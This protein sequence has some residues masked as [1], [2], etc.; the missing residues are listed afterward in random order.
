MKRNFRYS[1]TIIFALVLCIISSQNVFGWKLKWDRSTREADLKAINNLLDMYGESR[2]NEDIDEFSETLSDDYRYE[3]FLS[4]EERV[5][6]MRK[7]FDELRYIHFKLD[8]RNIELKAEEA[9]VSCRPTSIWINNLQGLSDDDIRRS[10]NVYQV[11]EEFR[12]AKEEAGFWRIRGRNISPYS[13]QIWLPEVAQP[14]S[15]VWIWLDVYEDDELSTGSAKVFVPETGEY[16]TCNDENG[17]GYFEGYFTAPKEPGNHEVI[18]HL[19]S[20]TGRNW[21]VRCPYRVAS[22]HPSQWQHLMIGT[23]DLASLKGGINTVAID[24]KGRLYFWDLVGGRCYR[25][26]GMNWERIFKY[27]T[28]PEWK[29]SGWSNKIIIDKDNNKWFPMFASKE[30]DEEQWG[31]SWVLKLND[32][33]PT[34][35]CECFTDKNAADFA[36]PLSGAVDMEGTVWIGDQDGALS[37]DGKDW[38]RYTQDDGLIHNIVNAITID[39]KGNR[40]FGTLYGISKFDG[41]KWENHIYDPWKRIS[42]KD[43]ENLEAYFMEIASAM[44][45]GKSANEILG[46][47]WGKYN[48]IKENYILSAASDNKGNVWF[49]TIGAGVWRY[50]SKKDEWRL[51]K[52]RDGLINNYI[53]SV[54]CDDEGNAW[55]CTRKGLSKFDGRSWETF[56]ISDGLC[57]RMLY[58]TE[59]GEQKF[60]KSDVQDIAVDSQGNRWIATLFGLTKFLTKPPSPPATDEEAIMDLVKKLVWA[61][62]GEDVELL[63]SLFDP[64]LK[65]EVETIWGKMFD[66]YDY[67]TE[68]L[69]SIVIDFQGEKEAVIRANE[70]SLL[71]R[72]SEYGLDIEWDIDWYTKIDDI[73]VEVK[74]A[75]NGQWYVADTNI[76]SPTKSLGSVLL[77]HLDNIFKSIEIASQKD[78]RIN[79]KSVKVEYEN[80]QGEIEWCVPLRQSEEGSWSGLFLMP[81]ERTYPIYPIPNLYQLKVTINTDL[82]EEIVIRPTIAVCY[83]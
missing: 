24:K 51:Y 27:Y 11:D 5:E 48:V 36:F 68:K 41:K 58:Q 35:K 20:K 45:E 18:V 76:L 39:S 9:V 46:V 17:D 8:K 67:E 40:W 56:T 77:G 2:L 12:L 61:L 70:E 83:E 4:K 6:K 42:D 29:M 14:G 78:D 22:Y 26:D 16:F 44:A 10:V 82:G 65:M 62:K 80:Y 66:E 25:Y 72:Q 19:T 52:P 54:N 32:D 37:Y 38:K 57:L 33:E 15:S 50:D 75:K 13:A 34:L 1:L 63:T 81:N 60:L 49:G 28:G 64:E 69:S 21:E 53:W 71:S 74:K 55:F 3:I 31:A 23:I 79:T 30:V 59:E 73:E 47:D 7:N 43:I